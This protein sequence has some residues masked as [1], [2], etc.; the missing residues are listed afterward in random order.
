MDRKYT[1]AYS[2]YPEKLK[3]R[4]KEKKRWKW[5]CDISF[6]WKKFL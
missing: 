5:T 6:T 1:H 3:N 4:R 2:S